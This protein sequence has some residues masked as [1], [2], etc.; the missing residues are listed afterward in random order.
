MSAEQGIARVILGALVSDRSPR[1]SVE[2]VDLTML[3]GVE[4]DQAIGWLVEHGYVA[5]VLEPYEVTDLGREWWAQPDRD[6]WEVPV[7]AALRE[8]PGEAGTHYMRRLGWT[9]GE[10]RSRWA[11]LIQYNL[12]TKTGSGS[13]SRWHLSSRGLAVLERDEHEQQPPQQITGPLDGFDAQSTTVKGCRDAIVAW[14]S[15]RDDGWTDLTHIRA[16]MLACGWHDGS[17]DADLRDLV[18]RGRIELRHCGACRWYRVAGRGDIGEAVLA[19]RN[20]IDTLTQLITDHREAM[21]S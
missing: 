2:L 7:L 10:Y 9:M 1:S 20:D 19:L 8:Q 6:S 16:W 18:I 3:A 17:V 13:A 12:V 4:V 11:R 14:L 5:G 21:F 15:L